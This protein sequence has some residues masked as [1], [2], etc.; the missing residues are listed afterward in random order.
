[1]SAND[2]GRS[3][4]SIMRNGGLERRGGS[5]DLV[6]LLHAYRVGPDS[7]DR[8]RETVAEAYPDADLFA[9]KLPTGVWSFRDP[10]AIVQDLLERIDELWEQQS[11]RRDGG[12]YERI[13]LVGHSLGGLLARKLYVCACGRT[14]RAPFE[15]VLEAEEPR[16]WAARIDR[17][18]L[19]AGMNRGWAVSHH[20]SL[21]NAVL[22]TIGTALGTALS[23]VR[24]QRPLIFQ[25]RRGAPFITQL[26]IQW[27]AMRHR[28]DQERH[29]GRER[30]GAA[31]V[32][33][34]LGSIDDMVAPEDNI[35]LV[36]GRDFVYLDVPRSGHSTVIEMDDSPAGRERRAV[37]S[38][39]LLDTP[40][41]LASAGVEPGD[42]TPRDPDP[43]VTDVVFVIHG[44]RDE[45]YWTHK[46]ARRTRLLAR[47][48][49]RKLATETSSYGYFPM[50]PFLLPHRRRAKVEWLMDQYTEDLALYPNADFSFV[51]HSNG[52][53]LLAKALEEYPACRFRYVV[54][55]GSVVRTRYDWRRMLEA[56]RV[57][58]VL[59]FVATRDWVVALFPKAL[60]TVRLQDLGSAG[61][62]G[63][64]AI[65]SGHQVC[66]VAGGHSAALREDFWDSIAHFVVHGR[67]GPLP[68]GLVRDEPS[69]ALRALGWASPLLWLV[70]IGGLVWGG[71]GI[72]GLDLDEA[73][74][75][76]FLVGYTG[77]VWIV[78]TRL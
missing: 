53:Y 44:I 35:D 29:A 21:K 11:R 7:L 9:P 17:I 75:T 1:M 2:T 60:Q 14:P 6:V 4:A 15:A 28:A 26:R 69:R 66:Y 71:L 51:G 47:G 25:V 54:F 64:F 19:L 48:A 20:L 3:K 22:W 5:R 50:L 37:F 31:L 57:R 72:W 36:T 77:L 55:A 76:L 45:G 12:G 39:S 41:R 62:D 52:T 56:G 46:I 18:I 34:L 59:N 32:V 43:E 49:G 74:R 42:L 10:N 33:Q 65:P 73:V 16:E 40:G 27:L 13:V 63:F 38:R 61:H 78:V 24:R 70:L 58:A 30:V 68:S 23:W 8:V 67:P